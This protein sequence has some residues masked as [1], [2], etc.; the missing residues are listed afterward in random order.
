MSRSGGGFPSVAWCWP[1]G[2]RA[3]LLRAA[4]VPDGAKAE[5]ALSEWMLH[6]QLDDLSYAE[7]RLLAAIADR[8]GDRIADSA[9]ANRLAGLQRQ[10]WTRSR[11]HVH[12]VLPILQALHAA[13]IQFMLLKGA[14]RV[15]LHPEVQRSRAHHDVDIL[16]REDQMQTAA[17]VFAAEGWQSARGDSALAAIARAPGTRAINFQKLPWGDV[18]LHRNAYHGRAAD[19]C[20]DAEMWRTAQSVTY[21]GVSALVPDA[22]ERLALALTHGAWSPEA[23]SDWLI[24]AADILARDPIDWARFVRLTEQRGVQQQVRI[25]LSYLFAV[26]DRT[27]QPALAPLM[28]G[29]MSWATLL[30]GRDPASLSGPLRVLRKGIFSLLR[31]DRR[32]K[33]AVGSPLYLGFARPAHKPDATTQMQLEQVFA[34]PPSNRQVHFRATLIFPAPIQTRRI[35]LELNTQSDNLAR[36]RIFARPNKKGWVKA[37]IDA[38]VVLPRSTTALLLLSSPSQLLSAGATK[39]EKNRSAALPFAVSG[40]VR[41]LP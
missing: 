22:A 11:M 37:T 19:A 2:Q 41:P 15:A 33:G 13:G 16:V 32:A 28:R 10:L 39:I 1:Q 40:S 20:C 21:F 25:G 26:T 5:A 34:V 3:L 31:H 29:R 4:L 7:H 36:F 6:N 18:D 9:L 38:K 23:H 35:E 8:F 17:I 24:D 12:H 27:V 30:I 14:A